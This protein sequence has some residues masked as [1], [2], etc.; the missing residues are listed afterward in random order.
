[1]HNLSR[2]GISHLV[3]KRIQSHCG[4]TLIKVSS[5]II[6]YDSD[7]EHYK[8]YSEYLKTEERDEP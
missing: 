2:V 8:I 5:N 7:P 3:T 4:W 6:L 1:M